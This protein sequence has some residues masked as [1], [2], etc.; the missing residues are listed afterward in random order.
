MASPAPGWPPNEAASGP[1]ACCCWSAELAHQP[2]VSSSCPSTAGWGG[3][4]WS[5]GPHRTPCHN[6][7]TMAW[8]GC[9]YVEGHP[10]LF[11]APISNRDRLLG[12]LLPPRRPTGLVFHVVG[13]TVSHHEAKENRGLR[14]CLWTVAG[15]LQLWELA[16]LGEG[17]REGPVSHRPHSAWGCS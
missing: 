7:G 9:G 11:P 12:G 1:T 15:V 6:K 13:H 17:T 10:P 4:P 8:M 14:K 3:S 2:P 16:E 5:V